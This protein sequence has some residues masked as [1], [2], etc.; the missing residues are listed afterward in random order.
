MRLQAAHVLWLMNVLLALYTLRVALLTMVNRG[1]VK[2]MRRAE[3][4][5]DAEAAF[6]A[7]P[8]YQVLVPHWE[9]VLASVSMPGQKLSITRM[10]LALDDAPASVVNDLRTET[11]AVINPCNTAAA[12]VDEGLLRSRDLGAI[13]AATQLNV[14][15][16]LALSEPFVWFE[17]IKVGRGRW[18]YRPLQI[19]RL[20]KELRA[21]SPSPAARARMTV[22]L[23]GRDRLVLDQMSGKRAA[24][25][26]LKFYV[27][28]P[29]INVRSKTRQN[30]ERRRLAAELSRLGMAMPSNPR[31]VSW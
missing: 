11:R 4:I 3:S 9:S 30:L 5:R 12:L 26:R 18:G 24:F 29:T 20:L 6:R 13:D 23:S 27:K 21:T 8:R 16:C 28:A 19:T 2:R 1:S 15:V 17:S 10:I 25:L 22:L 7:V 31:I 14:M